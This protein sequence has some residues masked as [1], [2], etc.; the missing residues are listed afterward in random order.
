M[1]VLIPLGI[2]INFSA[3]DLCETRVVG[4]ALLGNSADLVTIPSQSI[5]NVWELAVPP[6]SKRKSS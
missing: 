5:G 1:R 3:L 4:V 6:F 2:K